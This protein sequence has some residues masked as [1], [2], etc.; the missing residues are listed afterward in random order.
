M[1]E[2]TQ[3]DIDARVQQF[4]QLVNFDIKLG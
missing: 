3:A 1:K 4:V 2:I